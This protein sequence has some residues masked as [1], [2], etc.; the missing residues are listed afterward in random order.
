MTPPES[1]PR[2]LKRWV[3]PADAPLGLLVILIAGPIGWA[4]G[5]AMLYSVGGIG[6]LSRGWTVEPWRVAWETGQM[7]SS[8]G[9]SLAIAAVTTLLVTTLGVGLTLRCAGMLQRR[10]VLLAIGIGLGTPVMVWALLIQAWLGSSGWLSRFAVQA[11]L[12]EGPPAFPVLVQDR[13]AVGVVLALTMQLLP[14]SLLTFSQ[15]WKTIQG[16]RLRETAMSLG[17]SRAQAEWRIVLPVLIGRGRPVV[18]LTF[19]FALG[20]FEIPLLL[21]RAAP[22]MFSVVTYRHAGIFNLSDR[23][24]AFVMALVYFAVCAVAAVSLLRGLRGVER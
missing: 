6:R 17:A 18:A 16:D 22:Q 20:S 14:L 1:K 8:L 9:W 23:P 4:V 3:E 24:Q 2:R 13:W 21:G 5:Y 12:I 11:G 15:F 19:L 10:A 7:V